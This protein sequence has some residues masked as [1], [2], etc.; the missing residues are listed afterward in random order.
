MTWILLVFI[1]YYTTPS[2]LTA[3]FNSEKA[4]QEAGAALVQKWAKT[5]FFGLRQVQYVEWTCE[6]KGAGDSP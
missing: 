3:E 5:D 1:T 4:C 6:P 2:T